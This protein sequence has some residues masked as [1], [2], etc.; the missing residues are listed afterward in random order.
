MHLLGIDAA[1]KDT[2]VRAL[3]QLALANENDLELAK[4]IIEVYDVQ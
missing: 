3:N 4:T 1:Q 2:T